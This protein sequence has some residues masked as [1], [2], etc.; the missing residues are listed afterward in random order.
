MTEPATYLAASGTVVLT[1]LLASLP[2]ARK[3]T[4][5]DT[6]EAIRRDQASTEWST[7]REEML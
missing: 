3:A 1:V 4:S 5:A 7:A 6:L 2:P